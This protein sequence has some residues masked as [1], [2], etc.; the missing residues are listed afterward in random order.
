MSP[1]ERLAIG[2]VASC[3]L[4][5][6]TGAIGHFQAVDAESG[7]ELLGT[8]CAR[9]AEHGCKRAVGP[10]DGSTWAT[11]RLVTTRGEEP[12]FFLEPH[13]PAHWHPCFIRAGFSVLARYCSSL[14]ENL[15]TDG[16]R[17]TAI[18]RRAAAAGIRLR[19][20]DP[21]HSERELLAMHA[22]AQESFRDA[23]LFSPIPPDQFVAQ[24]APV[25]PFVRP[26][27]VQLAEQGGELVAFLFALPDVLETVPRTV[28]VKTVA[29]RPGRAYAGLARLLAARSAAAA[30]ALGF[31]RA[32]HALMHEDNMSFNWSARSARVIRRYALM[33]RCL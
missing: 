10:M 16:T 2:D 20:F 24:Y 14:Q 15:A 30:R 28:I 3:A 11:Y 1:D 26:E 12:A 17:L 25:L 7:A 32:I 23:F 6:T 33:G 29:A 4:W 19:T 9:L 8:A 18:E 27:L 31:A 13:T 22:L 5:W 21:N